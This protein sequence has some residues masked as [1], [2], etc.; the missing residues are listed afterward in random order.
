M[1]KRRTLL[2][3]SILAL[4]FINIFILML[5]DLTT[6]LETMYVESGYLFKN[7]VIPDPS[8]LDVNNTKLLD[9]VNYR[10]NLT[11]EGKNGSCIIRD[12]RNEE[13]VINASQRQYRHS[14]FEQGF[15]SYTVVEVE[16][17]FNYT[18]S[19]QKVV[20][21]LA[22]L[23]FVAMVISIV[24]FSSSIVYLAFT[25]YERSTKK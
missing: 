24:G 4:M 13:I 17:V 9:K 7:A 21:P 3:V 23:S 19:I 6:T 15:N 20:K 14:L 18:Y 5:I 8:R 2:M 25:M 10:V 11:I 12:L 1:V 16:G 22:Y